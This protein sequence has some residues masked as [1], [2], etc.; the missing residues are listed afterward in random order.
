MTLLALRVD[1]LLINPLISA[2]FLLLK[3]RAT[4]TLGTTFHR[5]ECQTRLH[6]IPCSQSV[7][8]H[9]QHNDISYQALTFRQHQVQSCH[10]FSWQCDALSPGTVIYDASRPCFSRM[11]SARIYPVN[12]KVAEGIQYCNIFCFNHLP[13]FHLKM[14][15][16]VPIWGGGTPTRFSNS[17]KLSISTHSKCVCV[18]YSPDVF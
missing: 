6:R 13:F 10:T 4:G 17:Y 18:W 14:S 3:P 8:R 2:T 9:H 16:M 7:Q 11:P 15:H 1:F 5:H 12:A